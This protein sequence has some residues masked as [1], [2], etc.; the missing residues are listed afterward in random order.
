M[1]EAVLES[2]S[3]VEEWINEG[4]GNDFRILGY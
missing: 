3:K 1:K 4:R 2:Q